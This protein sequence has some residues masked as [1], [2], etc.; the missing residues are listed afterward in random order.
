MKKM[1]FKPP[2]NSRTAIRDLMNNSYANLCKWLEEEF[3]NPGDQT[4]MA[5]QRHFTMLLS[6]LEEP[7]QEEREDTK[8]AYP[9]MDRYFQ[10]VWGFYRPS[11]FDEEVDNAVAMYYK[12][13]GQMHNNFG[14]KTKANEY[15]HAGLTQHSITVLLNFKT[16]SLQTNETL[17]AMIEQYTMNM[18]D[19]NTPEIALS[20]LDGII[21]AFKARANKQWLSEDEN[22]AS[23]LSMKGKCLL[24][25]KRYDKA[26]KM[27]RKGLKMFMS[28]KMAGTHKK[29]IT[30]ME[31]IA[32]SHYNLENWDL[33][34]QIF[35]KVLDKTEQVT[36]GI[37]LTIRSIQMIYCKA[38]I[39]FKAKENYK[40]AMENCQLIVL[41]F[42]QGV[43]LKEYK[44]L[45]NIFEYAQKMLNE[46]K[47]KLKP[48]PITKK[49]QELRERLTKAQSSYNLGQLKAPEAL[50]IVDEV[51][52]LKKAENEMSDLDVKFI[53]NFRG[54]LNNSLSLY[55]QAIEDYT[56][57]IDTWEHLAKTDNEQ[58][59]VL[60]TK[61]E[62][63]KCMIRLGFVDDALDEMK[64][65]G[66]SDSSKKVLEKK[67]D[68]AYCYL[69]KK[70]HGKAIEYLNVAKKTLAKNPIM[71]QETNIG[72]KFHDY[73]G[74]L[75]Y[76]QK[77]YK[78]SLSYFE[79]AEE[80]GQLTSVPHETEPLLLFHIHYG[81]C[82]RRMGEHFKGS[83]KM[84]NGFMLLLQK[85]QQ[86]TNLY[87]ALALLIP[88]A[89]HDQG[90]FNEYKF[91]L[92]ILSILFGNFKSST[93]KLYPLAETLQ[94]IEEEDEKKFFKY[95]YKLMIKNPSRTTWEWSPNGHVSSIE[96][97]G[98][99][100][101]EMRSLTHL[102]ERKKQ[103]KQFKNSVFI[104]RLFKTRLCQ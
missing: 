48:K 97:K 98:L 66:Q 83:K 100:E 71:M 28:F 55:G 49:Q 99:N 82:L 62:K 2:S 19:A 73:F 84:Q 43:Y 4:W 27:S 76:Q 74:L 81:Y 103:F 26:L 13:M 46:C 5:Q 95:V 24:E 64:K 68:I 70:D 93:L 96:Q 14:N 39:Y 67:L 56:N 35:D 57:I 37:D 10:K 72:V 9:K 42:R 20:A 25:L 45:A 50:K 40:K 61:N 52:S 22:H 30:V 79:K 91:V 12:A 78:R 92:Q 17:E 6:M 63:L 7:G 89:N 86:E 104:G 15:F 85:D 36:K 58:M 3:E 90:L 44:D 53:Y 31:T 29:M 11:G 16:I 94:I 1:V 38:V 34:L 69:L 77:N 101:L 33:A 41:I 59:E 51:I 18:I 54:H 80:N 102:R 21:D 23:A 65:F 8:C 47:N 75:Y 32:Y 88:I 60:E 87:R